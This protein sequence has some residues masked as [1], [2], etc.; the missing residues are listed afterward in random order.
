MRRWL[1]WTG[2]ALAALGGLVVVAAIA[3]FIRSE[4][5]LSRSYEVPAV[6]VQVPRDA[7]SIAAGRRLATVYGCMD[8]CH[9]RNGE[10]GLFFDEPLVARLTAPDLGAAAQ[11]YS[12]A[13]LVNIIRNGVRPDGT[14][15]FVMP[16]E[17]FVHLT[18]DDVGRIVAFVR[19]L[20]PQGGPGASVQLG[21]IGR[22]G[23]ASGKFRTAAELIRDGAVPPPARTE[24]DTRG[25][26]LAR[27]VCGE[28]H[29]QDLKGISTPDF[30][31]PDLGVTAAYRREDFFRLM[32]TGT[33]LGNR[34]LGLM[35]VRAQRNLSHMTDEEINALYS[36]LHGLARN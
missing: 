32:R 15:V 16:S 27:T 2:M 24:S 30:V 33:A 7:D 26:Y 3:I 9:G 18:D 28:C 1:R 8:G 12:D 6:S 19:T 17:A 23:V 34:E 14:S 29:G 11:R 31:A 10:G 5:A 13:Q 22:V 4:A 21:P 36:Y 25:R 35:R 20:S